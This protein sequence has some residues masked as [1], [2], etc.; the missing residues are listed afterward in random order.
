MPIAVFF[1]LIATAKTCLIAETIAILGAMGVV[2]CQLST[3]NC[4]LST[5]N[6]QLFKA[7]CPNLS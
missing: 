7:S 4:Q 3:V 5:V 2:N 6:C 1:A